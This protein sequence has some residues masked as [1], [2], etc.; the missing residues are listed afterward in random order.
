MDGH[1]DSETRLVKVS[2]S[3]IRTAEECRQKAY[4]TAEGFKSP[5][6]DVRVFF[7]GN[8]VDRAM[9]RWLEMDNPPQFWMLHHVDSIMDELELS[10]RQEGDGVVRWKHRTDRQQVR[11]FCRE[12]TMRLEELLHHLALPYDYQPAVRFKTP[13][14]IPSPDGNGTVKILLTGEMD[15]LVREKAPLPDISVNQEPVVYTVPRDS[16]RCWDLKVTRDSGYWRKTIAQL[17]FYDIA[18]W[19]MLGQTLDEAGLIQ[20]MVEGQPFMSFRPSDEDRQ[21]MFARIIRV[22]HDIMRGDFA[23]KADTAGCSRCEVRH[24][25]VKYRTEPGS[26]TVPLF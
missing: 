2:W 10:A 8:V 16:V 18:C 3:K 12:A 15:L 21:Q 25:C 26:K 17:V 4:L 11:E 1:Y 22:A 19:C 6:T 9:R 13:L 20:P 14:N 5:V 7:Q 23:P 24:A